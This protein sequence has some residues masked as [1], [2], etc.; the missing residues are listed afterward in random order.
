VREAWPDVL[1]VSS[2]LLT[3]WPSVRST[4]RSSLS[5]TMSGLM[6]ALLTPMK[7]LG[8]VRDFTKITELY[9]LLSS[10]TSC[11]KGHAVAFA[12][13]ITQEQ[14]YATKNTVQAEPVPCAQRI[15][16]PSRPHLT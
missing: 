3:V 11:L 14:S 16:T 7:F 10:E 2:L 12:R 4:G 13:R 9:A 1:F 6:N 5:F 15:I 8:L